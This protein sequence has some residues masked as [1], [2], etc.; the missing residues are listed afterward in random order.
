M[1][2]GVL[3]TSQIGENNVW[4][5]SRVLSGLLSGV[6]SGCAQNVLRIKVKLIFIQVFAM[7]AYHRSY[8]E[9]RPVYNTTV[10]NPDKRKCRFYTLTWYIISALIIHNSLHHIPF[11]FE[12]QALDLMSS[13]F[14]NKTPNRYYHQKIITESV[15]EKRI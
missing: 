5:L 12:G 10:N 11:I 14:P 6:L 3:K 9:P 8:F 13:S 1:E 7:P 2:L 4:T 15:Q